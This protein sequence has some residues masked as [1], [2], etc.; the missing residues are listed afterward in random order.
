[1]KGWGLVRWLTGLKVLTHKSVNLSS[2]PQT[3]MKQ[4]ASV[5]VSVTLAHLPSTPTGR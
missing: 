3:H 2:H 5:Q 1:M 4:D